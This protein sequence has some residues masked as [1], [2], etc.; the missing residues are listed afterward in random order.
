MKEKIVEVNCLKHE[1][2]DKTS[3]HFCGLEFC[4]REGER[5][6]VIGGNG[7]GKTTLLLHIM[8]ILTPTEG[9]V[10]VFGLSPHKS[11]HEVRKH[12]GVMFQN[13]EEQILGPTVEEDVAFTLKNDGFPREEIKGMVQDIL[14]KCNILPLRKKIPHYLSGGERRKVALAGSVVTRPKLLLLD[15]PFSGVD[16]K[17]R[18]ELI[19]LLNLF[20]QKFGTAVVLTT[21]DLNI[22][23]TIADTV[24]LISGGQIIFR[25]T[26]PELFEQ[27]QLLYSA[28]LEPPTLTRLCSD[29]K[30][31]GIN[32]KTPLS[33]GEAARE[34]S[35]HCGQNAQV[36]IP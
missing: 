19:S 9:Q 29:L 30:N 18:T 28:N 10:K 13:A 33:T 36:V 7:S 16:T 2:P 27:E 21:H 3:V 22:L 23:P 25:G 20:N 24:Y 32:I 17:N 31:M 5:V 12:I 14:E 4:V 6:A 1:Y 34:I 35:L 26:V 15:E 11:F 8:G